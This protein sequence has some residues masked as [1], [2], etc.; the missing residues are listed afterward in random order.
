V[1]LHEDTLVDT[2]CRM[3]HGVPVHADWRSR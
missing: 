1:S 2:L 3:R